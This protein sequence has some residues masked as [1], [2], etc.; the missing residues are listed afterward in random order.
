MASWVSLLVGI[1]WGGVQFAWGSAQTV[2]PITLGAVGLAAMVIYEACYAPYP[3]LKKTIFTSVNS[4][5]TLTTSGVVMLPVSVLLV[6]GSIVSGVMISQ[7]NSY[8]WAIWVGWTLTW[9]VGTPVIVWV[10]M[11]MVGGVG[12]GFMLNAQTF[13]SG[14]STLEENA[15]ELAA[16]Y[17]FCW[18]LGTAIRNFMAMKLPVELS[19]VAQHAEQYLAT[20]RS[21]L[22]GAF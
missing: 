16:I 10:V 14:V 4:S 20:L 22:S 11:L 21:L 9:G 13:V 7:L 1:S 5:Y 17:L 8:Q 3:F 15:V 2:A 6:L 12:Y 18:T 19:A